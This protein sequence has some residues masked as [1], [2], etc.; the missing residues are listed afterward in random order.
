MQISF[1]EWY[2]IEYKEGGPQVFLIDWV[3]PPFWSYL[4]SIFCSCYVVV[5]IIFIL[6]TYLTMIY[7][8]ALAY[9]VD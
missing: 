8:E 7:G 9:L 2:F 4:K 5:V 6:V 1:R 3:N